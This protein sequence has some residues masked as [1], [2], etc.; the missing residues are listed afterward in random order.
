MPARPIDTAYVEILPDASDFERIASREITQALDGVE[1][2]ARRSADGI[3]LAFERMSDQLDQIFNEI[4]DSGRLQLGLLDDIAQNTSMQI[5]R[6][7]E[8]AGEVAEDSF[9]DLQRVASIELDQIDNK[10]TRTTAAG[11]AKFNAMGLAIKAA[12][13]GAVLAAIAGLT[14]LGTMGL[15]TAASF[16]QTQISLDSLLGSA[17]KGAKLFEQLKEFAAVTPFELPQITD[18]AKRF[19]A[20]NEAIG[21]TDDQI[22]QFLTTIG[23]LSSVVG[24]G[25]E[26]INRAVLAIGQMSS[27]GKVQLEELM[28]ISEAFPGFSAIGAIA[29]SLGITTAEAMKKV[30]DGAI[31]AKTGVQ[32]LLDGMAKFPGA[33]GAMEKQAQT[34]LGV[35]STFKDTVT[36]AL[37]NAIAPA[38]PEI[39]EQ[40]TAITPIIGDALD[41][42]GPTLG[43]TMKSLLP[44]IANLI[45]ALVPILQPILD[46][47]GPALDAL[48]PALVPLGEAIGEILIPL[49]PLIPLIAQFAVAL[50]QLVVPV[51]RMIAALLPVITP[52][53]NFMAKA[54]AEFAKWIESINWEDIA[55]KILEW[56]LVITGWFAS[57]ADWFSRLPGM[58]ADAVASALDALGKFFSDAAKWF[59]D[60][61]GNI[62]KWIG[63]AA[64]ALF[65]TG[66]D[67]VRGLWDGVKSL[68]GWLWNKVKDFVKDNIVDA[69]KKTLHIGSPSKLM[70]DEVGKWIP[71]G[72]QMG[73]EQNADVIDPLGGFDPRGFGPPPAAGASSYTI[74]VTVNVNG[75]ITPQQA[76]EVGAGIGQG[77]NESVANKNGIRTAVR[78]AV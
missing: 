41:A 8:V 30:S 73:V 11:A 12:I 28:Q 36:Q 50:I 34:L 51:L 54:I 7:F 17:E 70:A 59:S 38:I 56:A 37:A 48:G 43:N 22:F 15:S 4:A 72:I 27:K 47:L 68:G 61:P 9:R 63:N 18:A 39:K 42:I 6:D 26:G 53:L 14:A 52:L 2:Q 46:A 67:F 13:I 62:I 16:E 57:V 21:L 40:L 65:D 77:I 35:F 32:A 49:V 45:E 55:N 23:D 69:A 66:K 71:A 29:E 74:S 60:L 31:D 78:M 25:A 1:R 24:S 76:R 10:I 64:T 33:A 19:L 75:A 44:L 3:E 5:G 58:I 20:F